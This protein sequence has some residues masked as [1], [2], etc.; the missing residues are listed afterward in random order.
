ME[1]SVAKAKRDYAS[2]LKR[3]EGISYEIHERRNSRMISAL[4][5]GH[6]IG[7]RER[8][9]KIL[10]SE[11]VEAEG[12]EEVSNVA[13]CLSDVQLSMSI[14]SPVTPSRSAPPDWLAH[15]KSTSTVDSDIDGDSV[16]SVDTLDD[17]TIEKLMLEPAL[18]KYR[19]IVEENE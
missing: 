17:R 2:A 3:L 16:A 15:R 13:A 8:K 11:R 10:M 12:A 19:D 18:D 14:M 4:P 5:V 1:S 7:S 6:V 9:Q